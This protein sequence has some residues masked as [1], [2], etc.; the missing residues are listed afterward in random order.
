MKRTINTFILGIIGI[1]F[2]FDAVAYS[3]SE[4]SISGNINAWIQEGHNL[5]IFLSAVAILCVH[6]I[7]GTYTKQ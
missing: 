6:W 2:V 1:I 3:I 4:Y 7:F 5:W